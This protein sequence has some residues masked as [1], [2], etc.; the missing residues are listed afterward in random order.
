MLQGTASD[1]SSSVTSV[2]VLQ[3]GSS[4]GSVTPVNG[5]WSVT[6]TNVSD[7]VHTYTLQT[8]DAAGNVGAGSSTLI[9]GSSGGDKIVGKA[10]NDVIHGDGGADTLTGGAGADVFVYTRWTTRRW[11]RPSPARS[12]RSPTSSRAR[13]SWTSPTWAT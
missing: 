3:D 7:A 8:T 10:T 9:L 1:A 13:T 6:K 4:I 11:A 5:A 12:I 2:N